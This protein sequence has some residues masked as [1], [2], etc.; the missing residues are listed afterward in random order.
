MENF[1]SRNE[2]GVVVETVNLIKATSEEAEEF[3]IIL[4]NHIRNGNI[5]LLI[6]LQRCIFIDS[7]FLSALIVAQKVTMEEGG[8]L[9]LL[10]PKNE[11]AE[12]LEATGMTKIFDIFSTMEKALPSFNS[13][14]RKSA[15]G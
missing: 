13:D 7:T 1:L 3:K 2:N 12:V 9:K 11:V 8:S 6:D 15:V 14:G 4:L 10:S 5:N